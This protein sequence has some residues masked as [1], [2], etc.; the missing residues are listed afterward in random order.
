MASSSSSSSSSS[1][2]RATRTRSKAAEGTARAERSSRR[3]TARR[4][5]QAVRCRVDRTDSQSNGRAGGRGGGVR[6]MLVGGAEH[7]GWDPQL[8]HVCSDS[9][10]LEKGVASPGQRRLQIEEKGCGV[11]T[12]GGGGCWGVAIVAITEGE[13]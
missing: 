9:G 3:A 13:H 1:S 11:G 6:A 7:V 8:E 2:T 12:R 5:E 10:I 4:A